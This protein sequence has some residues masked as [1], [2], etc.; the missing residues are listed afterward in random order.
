MPEIT[1]ASDTDFIR[2]FKLPG[3]ETWWTGYCVKDGKLVKAIAG[4]VFGDDGRYFAFMDLRG[5]GRFP[6]VFRRIWRFLNHELQEHG[7]EELYAVCDE[8][9]PNARKFLDRLGFEETSE[10]IGK[11][12]V[13][14]WRA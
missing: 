5:A 11:D 9:Y 14:I 6:L 8:A 2:F 1:K 10:V 4:V 3:L 7:V 12:K 13:W